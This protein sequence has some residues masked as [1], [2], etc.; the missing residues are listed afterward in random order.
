MDAAAASSGLDTYALMTRAGEAVADAAAELL[1]PSSCVVTVVAG[2]GNNG[3]DGAV[4]AQ[5]LRLQGCDVVMLRVGTARSASD[6]ERAFGEW[7][8]ES[9]VVE[10]ELTDEQRE[11]IKAADV[12]IDALLGAGLSHAVGG[13]YLELIEVVNTSAAHVVAVDLPS[14]LDGDSNL[15]HDRAVQADVTV[16]FV[17]YKPAHLLFPGRGLCGQLRLADIGMPQSLTDAVP[18]SNWINRPSLWAGA[19]T[20]AP[21][22]THKYLRGHVLV[23]S[24]DALSSGAARLSAS[25][26]L[27]CG[28]GAVTL[29][30]PTSAGEVNAC[31]LD[32]VM[33]KCADT[34]TEWSQLLTASRAAVSIVGPGNGVVEE[35]R[36]ATLAAL[37]AGCDCVLDAD[38]L[39]VFAG[40]HE[41]LCDA[42]RASAGTVV[43]TP[44]SAEFGRVFT[45]ALPEPGLSRLH[46]ARWA[47]QATGGVVVFKGPDTIV[48]TPDGR[49]SIACNAP[50]WLATA[51]AGDVL[52]GVIAALLAQGTAA[53]EAASM[54]VWAHGDGARQLGWPLTAES[55]ISATATSLARVAGFTHAEPGGLC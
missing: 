2:P 23:R 49:A 19:L 1:S 17:R 46:Q 44:H 24:G 36:L 26:A 39:S 18:V 14:G 28:A 40:D 12:V 6:A 13:V 38:A 31:H 8:G 16:T 34:A 51:G 41:M 42:V 30:C 21:A 3:G 35:T 11:R 53:F 29:V 33:L 47:A 5:R 27:G 7:T 32:A 20:C 25:S 10:H 15:P 37:S 4:A 48:A 9:L 22:E 43:M 50:P 52:A 45:N 55:L 54:A